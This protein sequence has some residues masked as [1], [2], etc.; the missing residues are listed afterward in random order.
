[1]RAGVVVA[2]PASAGR[3]RRRRGGRASGTRAELEQGAD[4]IVCAR[5][6]ER[7]A[8]VSGS[9]E[10]FDRTADDEVYRCSPT[11]GPTS[12]NRRAVNRVAALGRPGRFPSHLLTAHAARRGTKPAGRRPA[13]LDGE[14]PGV[15][16][17][18]SGCA[19]LGCA[20]GTRA[21]RPPRGAPL[22]VPIRGPTSPA[23]R[24][25]GHYADRA[26]PR[27]PRAV[28]AAHTAAGR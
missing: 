14:E 22:I 21:E 12:P 26:G 27:R 4:V 16:P 1:M 18:S 25:P 24:A 15:P 10:H 7:F 11:P 6:P 20:G 3:H 5:T 19:R 23:T 9:Y 8:A 28:V 17:G 13:E 2:A